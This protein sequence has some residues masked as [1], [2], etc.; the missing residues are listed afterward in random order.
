MLTS[1]LLIISAMAL[2]LLMAVYM[3]HISS[4]PCNVTAE[5]RVHVC[6]TSIPPRLH[7]PWVAENLHVTRKL[8]AV[9]ALRLYVPWH[10]RN[11]PDTP[12]QVP[13]LPSSIDV[14]RC[15]DHGP[16]TKL[17][18]P[19]QDPQLSDDDIICIIDDDVVYIDC[20]FAHLVAAIDQEPQSNCIY[21]FCS[22]SLAGF[23]GYGGLKRNWLPLLKVARPEACY[24]VDDD[25]IDLALEKACVEV[26]ALKIHNATTEHCSQKVTET[27][28]GPQ[29][30]DGHGLLWKRKQR[31]NGK[32]NCSSA[33][34]TVESLC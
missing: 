14:L 12:I 10:L 4:T 2:F 1:L 7:N 31:M 5:R 19:L 34:R 3:L 17:V 20:A 15:E 6:L 27:I 30:R 29:F 18:A 22:P 16:L 9:A 24:F 32:I 33:M 11:Q 21:S 23:R 8:R 28:K 25:F 26:R 13:P